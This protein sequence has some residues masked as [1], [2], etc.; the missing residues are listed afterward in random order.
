MSDLSCVLKRLWEIAPR[1]HP[2]DDRQIVG[3][4][5]IRV[6]QLLLTERCT[7]TIDWFERPA[8]PVND[9]RGIRSV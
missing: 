2:V 9:S 1:G 5:D 6:G 3:N 8:F 4:S 7:A